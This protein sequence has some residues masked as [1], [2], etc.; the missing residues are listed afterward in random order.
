MNVTID[1]DTA[2]M[3]ALASLKEA[4]RI[5]KKNIRRLSIP[6]LRLQPCQQQ[7]LADDKTFLVHLEKAYEYFGGKY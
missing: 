2:D 5:L 6:G 4:I 1:S 3:I 7:D